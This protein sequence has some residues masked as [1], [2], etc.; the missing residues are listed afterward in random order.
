MEAHEFPIDP[1]GVDP[2]TDPDAP[3][4]PEMP[5]YLPDW[6]ESQMRAYPVSLFE[7]AMD[8]FSRLSLGVRI[9]CIGCAALVAFCLVSPYVDV[10]VEHTLSQAIAQGTSAAAPDSTAPHPPSSTHTTKQRS[11]TASSPRQQGGGLTWSTAAVALGPIPYDDSQGNS[12]ASAHA[13]GHSHM[14][15]GEAHHHGHGHGPH[16]G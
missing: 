4:V 5:A 8:R 7:R 11:S 9:V 3:T 12:H 16:G 13:H 10:A 1:D 15:P 14:G 2:F 6:P